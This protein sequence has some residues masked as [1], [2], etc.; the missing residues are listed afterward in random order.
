MAAA[1]CTYPVSPAARVA[2][3][4]VPSNATPAFP[5]TA[6]VPLLEYPA[7]FDTVTVDGMLTGKAIPSFMS[8]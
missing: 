6:R 4:C 8:I 5:D 1:K 2:D 3:F 7:W